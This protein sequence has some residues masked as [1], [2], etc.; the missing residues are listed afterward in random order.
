MKLHHWFIPNRQNKFH[1]IALRP[2]GLIVFLAIF[3]AIPLL[4]NV[5]TAK[6]LQVLGYATSISVSDLN[7][8][9][10][11]QRNANGFPV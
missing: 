1:P 10:N 6:K 7:S 11:Q 2:L 3:F 8:L 4:Y 5:A 9:T